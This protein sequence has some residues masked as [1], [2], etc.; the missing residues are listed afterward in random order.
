MK[1]KQAVRAALFLALLA[2]VLMI[3]N[4]I[5]V[6]K[7]L[8]GT[9]ATSMADEFYDTKRDTVEL[10]IVGSSQLVFGISSGRLLSRYGISTFSCCTG[11]QPVLCSLF[12][13]KE[14]DKRQRVKV[15]IY[16][17]SML[18]EKEE[19]TRFRNVLD[20]A[21]MSINKLE[22]ILERS[23]S[24]DASDIFSYFI[25]LLNYHTRWTKLKAQD[26]HY[27]NIKEDMFW[28][29]VYAEKVRPNVSYEE[30]CV[31]GNA[32]DE[33]VQMDADELAAFRELVAYCREHD[34]ELVLV[35]T[36][37][38]TWESAKTIGCQALADEYGLDYFDF[39]TGALL[40]EIGFDVS[41][42]MSDREHMNVRGTDKMTDYMGEYLLT[43]YEF[44]DFRENPD[45]D[46]E[47]LARFEVCRADKYL[48]TSIRPQEYFEL[49]KEDRFE[50]LLQK[51]GE[52]GAGWNQ[53]LQ[54]QLQQLGVTA[55]LSAMD[56]RY[57]AAQL[58][59]GE[60]VLELVEEQP[61]EAALTLADG[62]GA[63]VRSD[64]QGAVNMTAAGKKIRF[65]Q[66][67]L[68]FLVYDKTNHAVV[69]AATIY[70]NEAGVPDMIHDLEDIQ[71][72]EGED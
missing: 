59:D 9:S 65:S 19:E 52:F 13:L 26:F 37:K 2:V 61:A 30:V 72:E 14:L 28:G 27:R 43:H 25:P 49:L 34:I 24:E 69:D 20:P 8:R 53:E 47:K 67:G 55:D 21:P 63:V 6:P 17:T 5:F 46:E 4:H 15:V 44:E 58:R 29:N 10:G 40:Q 35:K 64:Y 50:I 36:P 71:Q 39:N 31:D 1:K 60:A 68:N 3:V 38:L 33:T 62:N 42:D 22:L 57:Y 18:Y 11:E 70:L 12:Y 45:F 51:S 66:R 23:K 7:W 54:A 56:G 16:D 48:K 41:N 32:P